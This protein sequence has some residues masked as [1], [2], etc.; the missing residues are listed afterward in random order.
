[1]QLDVHACEVS[2]DRLNPALK[3][4]ELRWYPRMTRA[5][6]RVGARFG[7]SDRLVSWHLRWMG[8][9]LWRLVA[10][11][12]QTLRP[13]QPVTAALIP[14]RDVEFFRGRADVFRDNPAYAAYHAEY[15]ISPN[16]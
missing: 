9:K 6:R 12:L 2:L 8:S 16:P 1:M 7:G 14:E 13:A 11:S 15:L 3:P 4:F 5:L 10:R